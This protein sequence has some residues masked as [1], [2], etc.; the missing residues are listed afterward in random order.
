MADFRLLF[1]YIGNSFY[2]PDEIKARGYLNCVI[3]IESTFYEVIF[4]S[5]AGIDWEMNS[6]FVA[7]EPGII[8]IPELTIKNMEKAVRIL[9]ER[10]MFFDGLRQ[11][12]ATK[13]KDYK[14]A[15]LST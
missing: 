8:I 11:W 10:S 5:R 13:Y 15:D 3:E 4:Y 9:F 12:P 1:S 6:A 7:A 14:E 2:H